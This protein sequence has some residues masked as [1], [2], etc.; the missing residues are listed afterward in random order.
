MSGFRIVRKAF[1]CSITVCLVFTSI[2]AIKTIKVIK[3][4][5]NA[6]TLTKEF[7]RH[8]F[9]LLHWFANNV[10]VNSNGDIQLQFD[11]ALGSYGFHCH[12]NKIFGQNTQTEAFSESQYYS[13]GDLSRRSARMFPF[14]VTQDFHNSEGFPKKNTDRVLIHVQNRSPTKVEKVY[15]TEHVDNQGQEIAYDLDST[16]EISAKLLTQIQSLNNDIVCDSGD[17]RLDFSLCEFLNHQQKTAKVLTAYPKISGLEWFLTLAGYNIDQRF[18][19]FSQT[20]LC[21]TNHTANSASNLDGSC[22]SL[23]VEGYPHYKVKLEV[24]STSRGYAKV[25]W[26]G[27]PENVARTKVNI[28]LYKDGPDAEPIKEY[29]LNGRTFGSIDTGVPLNPGLQVQ[30]FTKEKVPYY[31]FFKS[32]YYTT[33]WKGPE[34]DEANKVLPTIIRG[35]QASLQL[36]TKDGYACARLYIKKSFTN[37]KNV[38]DYSW[39]GFYADPLVNNDDYK[40]YAWSVNFDRSPEGDCPLDYEIYQYESSVYIGPGVQA[41]FMLTTHQGSEKARTVPWEE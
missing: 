19:V 7:P 27:I 32:T 9:M 23:S 14:Y 2:T 5:N 28:G 16:Y 41:R 26:S 37:W 1:L 11:P 31:Y 21:M 12:K 38:F 13:L 20:F 35:Y 36:Y 15:L 18:D 4:L 6:T 24:I 17:P 3:D 40:A 34:F 22:S 30:L 25:I 8:G 33:I 29:S 10:D 39:V